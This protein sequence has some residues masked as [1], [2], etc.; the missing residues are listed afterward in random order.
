MR[1][2]LFTQYWARRQRGQP[3]TGAESLG[4]SEDPSLHPKRNV[5]EEDGDERKTG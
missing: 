5:H 2:V 1:W 4:S 3:H